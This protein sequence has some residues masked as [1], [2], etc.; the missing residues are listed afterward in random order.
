MECTYNKVHNGIGE[1]VG[2]ASLRYRLVAPGESVRLRI[3][4]DGRM[5]P[6]DL[7]LFFW[8]ESA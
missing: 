2:P 5:L 3:W 6:F 7:D 8:F 1:P 4:T